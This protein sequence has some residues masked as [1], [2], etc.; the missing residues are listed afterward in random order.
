MLWQAASVGA[1]DGGW[2]RACGR[3]NVADWIF[4]NGVC[5]QHISTLSFLQ[6][7]S[8]RAVWLHRNG[9]DG[10]LQ[11]LLLLL[12]DLGTCSGRMN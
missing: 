12:Y 8:S 5:V 9:V 3:D 1:N 11:Y 4:I 7:V 10:R 2:T 6:G